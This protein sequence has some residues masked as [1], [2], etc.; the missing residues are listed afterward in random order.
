MDEQGEARARA[1]WRL[2]HTGWLPCHFAVSCRCD[3]ILLAR[4][5]LFSFN[6]CTFWLSPKSIAC[7]PVRTYLETQAELIGQEAGL[8]SSCPSSHCFSLLYCLYLVVCSHHILAAH[9]TP[10]VTSQ[11]TQFQRTFSLWML[12][13]RKSKLHLLYIT[14]LVVQYAGV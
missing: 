13:L 9:T 5:L 2:I 4:C 8:H 6:W 7:N 12:E 14:H 11:L 3:P 1:V 10:H